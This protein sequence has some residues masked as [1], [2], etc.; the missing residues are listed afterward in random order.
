[1]TA[2]IGSWIHYAYTR[3]EKAYAHLVRGTS[4]HEVINQFGKPGSIEGCHPI[5]SWDDEPVDKESAK[6]VEEFRYFS[7][8]RIGAWVVGFDANGRAI[9]KY[10]ESSP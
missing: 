2:S 4:K 10:Y 9:T 1:M 5:P 8:L 3:Y 6:C 7:R